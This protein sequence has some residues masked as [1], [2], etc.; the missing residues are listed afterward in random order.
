VGAIG[1]LVD[2]SILTILSSHMGLDVFRARFFSFSAAV[3]VTWLLNRTL[4]FRTRRSGRNKT[5]EYSQYLTVQVAGALI[6]LAVFTLLVMRF[7]AFHET[8][9]IPLAIAASIALVF[10]FLAARYWVYRE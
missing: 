1:F 3:T 4:V 10:N 8:P 5:T 9:V 2:A 7:P 6:N